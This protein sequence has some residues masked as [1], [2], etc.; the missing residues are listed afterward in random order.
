MYLLYNLLHCIY[1]S[2]VV[3]WAYLINFVIYEGLL[4]MKDFHILMCIYYVIYND[5]IYTNFDM[6]SI[7]LITRDRRIVP[8]I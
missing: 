7:Y 2:F 1:S 6:E 3:E 8:S 4:F 5:V